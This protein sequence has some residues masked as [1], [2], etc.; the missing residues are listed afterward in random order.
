MLATGPDS[1]EQSFESTH[2]YNCMTPLE[3]VHSMGIPQ[4]FFCF[5]PDPH[6]HGALGLSLT[7]SFLRAILNPEFSASCNEQ[8]TNHACKKAARRKTIC[9]AAAG[10]HLTAK[11]TM[12][13]IK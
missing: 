10:R 2:P 11:M 9:I 13:S 8:R 1:L 7:L 3:I 5:F 12:I 4:H 6:A